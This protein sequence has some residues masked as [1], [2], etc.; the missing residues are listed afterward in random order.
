MD[1][2]YRVSALQEVAISN[3]A[4]ATALHG[5]TGTIGLKGSWAWG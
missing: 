4:E 2:F 5:V 3:R 1:E